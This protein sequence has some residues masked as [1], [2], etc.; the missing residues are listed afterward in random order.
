[1]IYLSFD[2]GLFVHL[3]IIIVLDCIICFATNKNLR[4]IIERYT[5][6]T[7]IYMHFMQVVFYTVIK[8]SL[9]CND[10]NHNF[11]LLFGQINISIHNKLHTFCSV[12]ASE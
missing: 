6:T 12:W 4:H 3:S 5:V 8:I 1:M 9:I 11:I 2:E 7:D 10:Y